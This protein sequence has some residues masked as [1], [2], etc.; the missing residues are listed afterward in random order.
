MAPTSGPHDQFDF[1]DNAIVPD[2]PGGMT[3]GGGTYNSQAFSDNAGPP[4]QIFTSPASAP[5]FI[6]KSVSLKGANTGGGN[7]GGGVFTTATWGLRISSVSGTTLTPLNTVTGIPTV[8]GATGI[9]WYTWSFSGADALTLNPTTQYAFEVYS[10]G[11][12]LGFDADTGDSY[13]G[14]TAFNSAGPARSF[15]DTTTGNLANHLYDR[16]FHVSLLESLPQP[17][18]TDGDGDVDLDDFA[19]IRDHFRTTVTSRTEGD[20]NEDGFVDFVD[21]DEWKDNFPFT[22]GSGSGVGGSVPEPSSL[23]LGLA[24]GLLAFCGR[25]RRS[26]LG[27]DCP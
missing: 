26:H 15:A 18:D 2:G 24:A 1:T 16:T 11:G 7:S 12:Y 20:L 21:F 5:S 27:C 25:R 9:E 19:A 10:S 17:G 13:A 22:P 4:G 8:P 6:L 23:M 3:P 14:G